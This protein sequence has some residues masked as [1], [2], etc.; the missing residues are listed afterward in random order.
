MLSV[1]ESATDAI[2]AGGGIDHLVALVGDGGKHVELKKEY[3]AGTLAQ[4]AQSP[5]H[6]PAIVTSG[7][8]KLLV[9]I[10]RSGKSYHS[11]RNA[12]DA[13][14]FLA[15]NVNATAIVAAKGVEALVDILRI[16]SPSNVAAQAKFN[17]TRALAD[18]AFFNDVRATIVAAGAIAPLM[19][20][21]RDASAEVS[22][23][24]KFALNRLAEGNVNTKRAICDVE[25]ELKTLADEAR[26]FQTEVRRCIGRLSRG[27]REAGVRRIADCGA[28]FGVGAAK[29]RVKA[30]VGHDH[31]G[32]GQRACS[33]ICATSRASLLADCWSEKGE[34]HAQA[35][36]GKP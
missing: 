13:L 4:I 33:Q 18:L 32:L 15:T 26:H 11:K 29:R 35:E 7:A 36:A 3:A 16:N 30:G 6:H 1:V 24:A 23:W 9:S 34:G 25:V 2:V 12:A 27:S 20:L 19:E 10:A 28:E 21:A 5:Q 14:Y 31:H 8:I 22:A 17:A